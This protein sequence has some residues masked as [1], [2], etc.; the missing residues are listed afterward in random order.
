MAR[1]PRT[2]SVL[3][4]L[5]KYLEFHRALAIVPL[6]RNHQLIVVA[7]EHS[8]TGWEIYGQ[9]SRIFGGT[10]TGQRKRIGAA[11]EFG[12][13]RARAVLSLRRTIVV[14]QWP[15]TVHGGV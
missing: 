6:N 2:P 11:K 5:N 15:Q 1:P 3:M 4:L 9:Q 12:R 8:V 14:P 7:A 13:E 10:H